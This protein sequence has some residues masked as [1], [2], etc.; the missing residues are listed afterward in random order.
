MQ[1]CRIIK[2]RSLAGS[3]LFL[4]FWHHDQKVRKSEI[5]KKTWYYAKY[6]QKSEQILKF[7]KKLE[8]AESSTTVS[9]AAFKW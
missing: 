9:N 5:K 1:I 3:G 2:D 6:I 4:N 8:R 7:K